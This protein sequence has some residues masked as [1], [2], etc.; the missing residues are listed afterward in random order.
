[1]AQV[2]VLYNAPTDPVAFQSYY[3]KT[4]IPLAKKIPGLK[5]YTVSDGAVQGLAGNAAYLVAILTFDSMADL[6]AALGSPEG[7]A[8]AADVQNF[9]SGGA[10]IMVYE[11]KPA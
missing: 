11:C 2:L 10:T 4:H 3:E 1:M 9:A 6:Q 5:S 7:Q 8:T